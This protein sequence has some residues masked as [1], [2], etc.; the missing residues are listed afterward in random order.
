MDKNSNPEVIFVKNY[1][2]KVLTTQFTVNSQPHSLSE[3][4]A[5]GG[6]LNPTLN[7]VQSFEKLNN[8]FTPFKIKDKSG[9]YIRYNS[10]GAIFKGRDARLAGTVILPGSKFRGQ[11]V[12]IFAG[13]FCHNSR[14]GKGL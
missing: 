14:R 7:F 3:E 2:L 13:Y 10:A 4:A 9:K 12:N 1:K 6:M 8:T 11:K 5:R